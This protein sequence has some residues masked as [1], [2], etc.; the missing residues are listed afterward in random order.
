LKEKFDLMTDF[1]ILRKLQSK[2][3]NKVVLL[4]LDGLGGMA[5]SPGGKTE[6]EAA[7]TP[8]LD[9]MAAEGALGQIVPILRGITPGSGPA[10]L[11]LFGYDP[12]TYNVG[13]GVLES[14]GIGV[15]V[16]VGD[17]AAR[18]N[19]CTIDS[20][21]LISDRRAGRISTPNAL[22]VVEKLAAIEIPG[23]KIDVHH[24]KEH[25]FAIVMR[26]EGLSANIADT[27]PQQT[28][29]AP[30]DAKAHDQESQRAADLFN[31]WIA[32]AREALKEE[33]Q[34][35][36][37]TLRGFSSD[38]QLPQLVDFTGMRPVCVA[39]YPMYKGVSQLV[40]MHVHHFEGESPEDEFKALAE[41]W[42]DYDYFFVHIKKTDSKGEDGNFQGKVDIIEGLD[43]ALPM[44]LDLNPAAVVVTGDHS[45][46]AKLAAHSWHP[47]PLL[48]WAP[49]TIRT[50]SQVAFGETACAH[51]GLGTFP[52]TD[53]LP[54][55]M[56]HAMK[57]E[58][59]GA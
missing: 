43:A 40:G 51:G 17:V 22:P 38:P 19:F 20:E 24:V 54:I 7:Q 56:A 23:V 9:Q 41:V 39:V 58:K 4:V 55:L 34:A 14:A 26:G 47:V 13:R 57:L 50:D 11:S 21:G 44:L 36:A 37:L 33:P 5:L 49:G 28:G 29:V 59:Y 25:R 12:I 45:T 42:D 15:I 1:K 46:P 52:S 35:N 27:D 16:N 3:N 6:L 48:L 8:N 10:H 31:Q 32:K 30:F 53:I 18:G 2:N